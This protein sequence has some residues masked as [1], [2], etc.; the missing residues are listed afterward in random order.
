MAKRRN[1]VTIHPLNPVLGAE[2]SGID[3]TGDLS[4]ADIEFIRDALTDYQVIFFR[5]QPVTEEQH[6]AFGKRFGEL[7]VHPTTRNQP[8]EKWPDILPV[9]ADKDTVRTVGDKWHAD[10]TCDEQAPWAS[11]LHMTV[12]PETGGDTLFSSAAAAYEAL[13]EP[14]KEMLKGLTATHDGGPNYH[15]RENK[16]DWSGETSIYPQAVHPVVTTHPLSG[17]SVLYVNKMFTTR[18]NEV[19]E[20]ESEMLLDYLFAHVAK[21][22]FQCRF[23]WRPHSVAFWDNRAVQHLAIW[24]YYPQTRSGF[25]VTIRGERPYQ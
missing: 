13:S 5:D 23:S 4:D 10:V 25:R 9:H 7:H 8:R 11:I 3:L 14:M 17:R 22:E 21:P 6:I 18:I 16:N 24:D 1:S 20:A 2:L 15:D 19:T 12:L